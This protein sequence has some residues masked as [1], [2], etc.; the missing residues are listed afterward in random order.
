[1]RTQSRSAADAKEAGLARRR[2]LE[3]FDDELRAR[4]AY[5]SQKSSAKLRGV[6]FRFDF[7][8]WW[9]GGRAVDVGPGVVA[10]LLSS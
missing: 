10:V 7:A 4:R 5:A 2:Q 8:T 6:A 1:M 3:L 9:A